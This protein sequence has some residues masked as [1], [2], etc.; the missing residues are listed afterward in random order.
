MG[1]VLELVCPFAE[2]AGLPSVGNVLKPEFQRIP[3]PKEFV[4]VDS[5]RVC[6][7]PAEKSAKMTVPMELHLR[8]QH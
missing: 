4:G 1:G 6:R 2:T 8:L 3:I 5:D 7:I